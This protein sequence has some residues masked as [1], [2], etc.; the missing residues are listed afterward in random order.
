MNPHLIRN[1]YYTTLAIYTCVEV[2]LVKLNLL[3][4][5]VTPDDLPESIATA[6]NIE[7]HDKTYLYTQA[8]SNIS[9]V[10]TVLSSI[11]IFSFIHFGLFGLFDEYLR[12]EI[13]NFYLR[14]VLF[15]FGISAIMSI[16][17]LPLEL[18][19]TFVIEER[20]GFNKTTVK[21][22]LIDTLKGLILSAILLTPLLLALL[23]FI[24]S[25]PIYW[26]FYGFILV[27]SFQIVLLL[28]FP[29]V[30]APLFN[31]FEKLKSEELSDDINKLA[32]KLDFETS[33]IFQ[34]DGS[35]RSSHGN[36][37]FSG[38]GKGRRIVLFDTLI[39]SLSSTELC[40]V[41]AH[42]I[43]HAK[44][45]HVTKSIVL[46]LVLLLIAFYGASLLVNSVN[47]FNA[48]GIQK[49]SSYS[50][51]ILM[52]VAFEPFLFF[53]SPIMAVNSRKNEYEADRY[54]VDAMNNSIDLEQ[55]L[56]KL[57]NKSLSNLN[58]HPLYSF[59]HYSHPTLIERIQAMNRYANSKN[60]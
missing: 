38:F 18:Y 52:S 27:A 33:G 10:G 14:G 17:Q 53:I 11:I 6:H 29:S 8:K 16:L 37:Y 3:S 24:E 40:S 60:L 26:W 28:I 47:F 12:N 25:F 51:L 21:L 19:H 34:M 36:A 30:I 45:H 15:I 7:H 1:L 42:E 46:S 31:K 49:P 39:D 2:V 44:K 43:G 57:S 55:A 50:L 4:A 22:W 13:E 9:I 23:Y 56:V 58:P 54:A 41:L 48:F 35:K 20:F 32:A 5:K 59:F